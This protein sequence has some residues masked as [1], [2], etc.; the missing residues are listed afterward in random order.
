LVVLRLFLSSRGSRSIQGHFRAKQVL[1]GHA[2][3]ARVAVTANILF[4]TTTKGAIWFAGC[5]EG[6][7]KEVTPA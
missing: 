3:H 4:A 1:G 7:K 6:A 5:R 2:D